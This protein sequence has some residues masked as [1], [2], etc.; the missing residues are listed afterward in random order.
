[1]PNIHKFI[2]NIFYNLLKYLSLIIEI[3]TKET[4]TFTNVFLKDMLKRCDKVVIK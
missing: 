3:H 4:K 1:M 2:I